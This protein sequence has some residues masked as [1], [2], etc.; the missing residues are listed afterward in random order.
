MGTW[1]TLEIQPSAIYKPF[2]PSKAR[3]DG[4]TKF[5]PLLPR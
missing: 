1:T 3:A 2:L 5:F 4:P